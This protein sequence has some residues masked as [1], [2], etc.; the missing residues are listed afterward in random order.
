MYAYTLR[1]RQLGIDAVVLQQHTVIA[2]HGILLLV[3]EPRLLAILVHGEHEDVDEIR[4]TRPAQPRM[5]KAENSLVVIVISRSLPP[6]RRFTGIR[7]ELH[8]PERYGG[9]RI[10]VSTQALRHRVEISICRSA[11][12]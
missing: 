12:I 8:H 3:R 1:G 7:R 2:R 9:T 4:S 11:K 6:V 5:R 10:I